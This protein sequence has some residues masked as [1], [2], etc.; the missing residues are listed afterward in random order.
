MTMKRN[1]TRRES[2]HALQMN[3]MAELRLIGHH[4]ASF[5]SSIAPRGHST[6]P[7]AGCAPPADVQAARGQLDLRPL[8]VAQLGCSQAVAVADQ[9]HGRVAMAQ[10]LPFLAAAIRRSISR[11]VRYSRVRT[12]ELTVFGAA[13]PPARFSTIFPQR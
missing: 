2:Q 9:D 6:F 13:R 4:E 1:R 5:R 8:Q 12:R 7:A 11:P 3:L 10:R